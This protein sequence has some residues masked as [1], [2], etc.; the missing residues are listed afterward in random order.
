MPG[1]PQP[2]SPPAEQQALVALDAALEAVSVVDS[3]TAEDA[4]SHAYIQDYHAENIAARDQAPPLLNDWLTIT[5]VS[6]LP[7]EQLQNLIFQ[8]MLQF[9]PEAIHLRWGAAV[10]DSA[11]SSAQALYDVTL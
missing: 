4:I 9:H 11:R 10:D 5:G 2:Q 8:E 6:M 1:S 3:I 7:K